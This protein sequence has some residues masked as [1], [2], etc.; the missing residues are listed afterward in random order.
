MRR[1]RW[2]KWLFIYG[3]L[4]L[5]AFFSYR[6]AEA[7]R[8]EEK[9]K[10]LLATPPAT[11]THEAYRDHGKAFS[12]LGDYDRAIQDYTQAIILHPHNCMDIFYFRGN[13]YYHKGEYELAIEDY[14][15]AIEIDPNWAGSYYMRGYT[16]A[17]LGDHEQA[18][19]DMQKAI[20]LEPDDGLYYRGRAYLN[21]LTGDYHAAFIAYLVALE[22]EAAAAQA[23]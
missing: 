14:D 2:I 9:H 10:T 13:A 17:A 8:R 4:A 1:R 21:R 12:E 19:A 22:K 3:A 23:H 18:M 7:F 20:E 16:Y 15:K 5:T 6:S 11:E